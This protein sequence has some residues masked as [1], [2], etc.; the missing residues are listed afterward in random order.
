LREF[1]EEV[2]G[3]QE[4]PVRRF[5]LRQEAV[6]LGLCSVAATAN[7]VLVSRWRSY[8]SQR[9]LRTSEPGHQHFQDF[10]VAC[11]WHSL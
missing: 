1:N 3:R 2:A 10:R 8:H 6:N 5:A 11:V 7:L 9:P 4:W